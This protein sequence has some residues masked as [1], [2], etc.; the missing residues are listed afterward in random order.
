MEYSVKV[1][2]FHDFTNTKQRVDF[3][4]TQFGLN[5]TLA[6]KTENLIQVNPLNQARP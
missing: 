4:S 2:K 6:G 5:A 1:A 3:N